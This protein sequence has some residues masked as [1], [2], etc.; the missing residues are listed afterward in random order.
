M[1]DGKTAPLD[2]QSYAILDTQ[3]KRALCNNKKAVGN[4]DMDRV[5]N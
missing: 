3:K 5:A 1:W 2:D 4:Q